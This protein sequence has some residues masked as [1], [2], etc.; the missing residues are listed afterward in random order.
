M[1]TSIPSSEL[2]RWRPFKLI[3]P[4]SG[5]SSPATNFKV[6]LLPAPE[7]PNKTTISAS[8]LNASFRLKPGN[9][10]SR[11]NANIFP[12][13]PQSQTDHAEQDKRYHYHQKRKDQR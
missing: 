2:N 7:G 3:E 9:D 10:F 1:G 4:E 6:R 13:P 8:A 5:R 12:V 11:S